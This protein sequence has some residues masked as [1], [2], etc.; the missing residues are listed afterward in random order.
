MTHTHPHAAYT[1]SND[2][3]DFFESFT[4]VSGYAD[5]SALVCSGRNKEE[6]AVA[7][8]SEAAKVYQW[9][10]DKHL[11]LNTAKSEVAFFS[12]DA[13]ES[14]WCSKIILRGSR[15]KT[16]PTPTLLRVRY[17]HCLTFND[18]VRHLSQVMKQRSNL[19]TG[20]SWRWRL[21]EAADDLHS[22]TSIT[23]RI[24]SS[25]LGA[26]G[27]QN[28]HPK[29]REGTIGRGSNNYRPTPIYSHWRCSPWSS[30]LTTIFLTSAGL[31]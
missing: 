24:R 1:P 22:H 2:L 10:S 21:L 7:L 26:L 17:D 4:L 30:T 20:M 15:L 3:L 12:M 16:N 27:F 14:S 6:V 23:R 29:I 13:S 5:D 11:T 18:H 28:Y 9:A 25:C 31:P 8:E 19:L